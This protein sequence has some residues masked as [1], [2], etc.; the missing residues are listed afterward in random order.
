M[1]KTPRKYHRVR[2]AVTYGLSYSVHHA[3]VI[4]RV[5]R[6]LSNHKHDSDARFM[7]HTTFR[8]LESRD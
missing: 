5:K 7:A 4:I 1:V 3:K 8:G 2:L 6:P